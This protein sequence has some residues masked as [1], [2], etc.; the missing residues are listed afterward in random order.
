[1]NVKFR[2]V[3][4]L[5]MPSHILSV[6]NVLNGVVETHEETG[7]DPSKYPPYAP[8]AKILIVDDISANLLVMEGLLSLYSIKSDTAKRGAKAIEMVQ[9]ENYDIIFMDHMMPEMDGIEAT[10]IIRELEDDSFKM[11][12]IVALTANAVSGMREIF[13]ENGMNDFLAKP[14]EPD[15][16]EDI[17]FKWLPE[18]K[19]K[20]REQAIPKNIENSEDDNEFIKKL[21]RIEDISIERALTYAGGSY[22]LLESNVRM[23]TGLLPGSAEKLDDL[24]ESD[25]SLFAIHIHGFKN[26]LANIGAYLLAESAQEIEGLAKE[27]EQEACNEL[28]L[29]FNQNA[30]VLIKQLQTLI[31]VAEDKQSG[32]VKN[33]YAAIQRLSE[34]VE[35]FDSALALEIINA[36]TEFTY[37]GELDGLLVN[38]T[39]AFEQFNFDDAI[40]IISKIKQYE[41]VS[42]Q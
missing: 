12:P 13:L 42:I 30:A 40:E 36:L 26:M 16:L 37:G 18:G 35:L 14:V 39:G 11:L 21:G 29:Q 32:D 10:H 22:S 5:T 3:Q 31:S 15:K 6:A 27:G 33:V 8:E 41:E 25:I 38:L 4:T 2:G 23:I 34:A 1:D 7:H 19:I 24:I 28:Y 17:L 9:E 20:K